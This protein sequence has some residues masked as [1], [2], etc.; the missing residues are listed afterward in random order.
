[1]AC[2]GGWISL[3]IQ[4]GFGQNQQQVTPKHIL[5]PC[6]RG[7]LMT[8]GLWF[9][10]PK[11]FL[12]LSPTSIGLQTLTGCEHYIPRVPSC[13]PPPRCWLVGAGRACQGCSAPLAR[14]RHA[15]WISPNEFHL[16]R[17]WLCSLTAGEEE[18]ETEQDG[19]EEEEEE[20][21]KEEELK[22]SAG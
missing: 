3:L 7:N 21:K 10:I 4:G 22:E 19:E 6:C 20:G 9:S 12:I 5:S 16:P 8:Q 2:A 11:L 13:A 18:E 17:L 1:M 14:F 15:F